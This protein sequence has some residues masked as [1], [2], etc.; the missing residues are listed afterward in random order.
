MASKLQTNSPT[1]GP[2]E[3]TCSKCGST[4]KID[5]FEMSKGYRS[6]IC[7]RCRSRGKR[8][9][10]SE[11]PYAYLNNLYGQLSHKRRKTHGFSISKEDLYKIYDKQQGICK[12]SGLPMTYIKD[13]SGYH[14]TNISI[15]RLDNDKGY[16]KENICLVCLAVNMMKYTLDLN[17]LIDW[18]TLI[19]EHNKV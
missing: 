17:E 5:R 6:N 15:D 11:S 19:A 14:L 16:D 12:Y 7:R 8:K 10:I 18:C 9:R 3:K 13:G 4:K 2:E 1:I